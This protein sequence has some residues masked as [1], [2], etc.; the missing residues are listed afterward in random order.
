MTENEFK[1]CFTL[2]EN[3]FGKQNNIMREIWYKLFK[4]YEKEEVE[5][6]IEYYIT[7]IKRFPLIP[8]IKEYTK[9]FKREKAEKC[10]R[11]A[12]CIING[13]DIKYQDSI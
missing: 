8:Y 11:E 2:L 5:K 13:I 10:Y 12:L 6:A 1:K 3:E 4:D 9:H 7:R